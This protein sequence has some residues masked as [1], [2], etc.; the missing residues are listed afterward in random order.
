MS[1]NR[2]SG[3]KD[4]EI[5]T[6]DDRIALTLPIMKKIILE[7][8]QEGVRR[9]GNNIDPANC[10]KENEAKLAMVIGSWSVSIIIPDEL[11]SNCNP[12]NRTQEAHNPTY[13]RLMN[14]KHRTRNKILVKIARVSSRYISISLIQQIA[15]Y[16]SGCCPCEATNVAPRHRVEA[17]SK[18]CH[19][20]N[21]M[22][23][24]RGP[25][26][27]NANLNHN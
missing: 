8:G 4:S 24:Q 16:N 20:H 1:K 6:N 7:S 10:H 25:F 14:K 19:L 18:R 23:V 12:R 17:P 5:I 2:V 27:Q 22:A 13:I 21:P 26:L 11:R 15:R 3:K 9:G